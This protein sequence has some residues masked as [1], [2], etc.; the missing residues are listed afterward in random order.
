[1]KKIYLYFIIGNGQSRKPALCQLYR[2]TFVPYRD[3]SDATVGNFFTPT[4]SGGHAVRW[5]LLAVLVGGIHR[6]AAVVACSSQ[7]DTHGYDITSFVLYDPHRTTQAV[8]SEIYGA[9]LHTATAAFPAYVRPATQPD[10]AGTYAYG[11]LI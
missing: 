11:W 9:A 2:H 4:I 3:G 1:L 10:N 5:H 7:R 8:I 6:V